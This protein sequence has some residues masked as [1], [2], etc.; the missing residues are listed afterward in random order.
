MEKYLNNNFYGNRSYGVAAAAADYWRK[1]LKDLTLAAVRASSP[2]SRSPPPAST[3]S[4]TPSRRPTPTRRAPSRRGSSCPPTA[5]IVGPPQPDPGPD[6][7]AERCSPP[8][9]TRTPTTRPPSG[10][11]DPGLAGG[12]PVARAAVRVAG[13]RRAR[14]DPVRHAQCE[15][16]D[17]G[18]YKVL[19]TLDYRM[20]RIVEKWV[21]AAAIIPNAKSPDAVL[22]A[23]EIPSGEWSW[24]KEPHAATTSTTPPRASS[25]YR[26]GEILAYAG[27][28]SYTAKGSKKFQPQFDV[29]ADGWRQ[30]GSSIKPLVYL[31]RDRRPDDDRGHDVHGRRDEL[32]AH[33]RQ[34]R[35]SRPRPTAPSAARSASA[36]RSSSR[37]TSRRSRPASSTASTTSS[38][39]PRTSASAYP[40]RHACRSPPRASGP[41]RCTRST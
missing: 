35:S 34:G 29:L 10:A 39:G 38:S 5:P 25:D 12:R 18:G 22:K 7:D 6:E 31:D 24:I 19:T 21:Y 37:S 2:A 3:S 4:R 36:T 32:R 27:S 30:P 8:A 1:D 28:A 17:T 33:R 11:G 9:S 41:S 14:P 15:K 40:A 13:A 20:Q 16:I 23:R 26:T